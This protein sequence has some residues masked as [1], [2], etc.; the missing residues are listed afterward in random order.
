[1]PTH[2]AIVALRNSLTGSLLLPADAAYETA[3]QPWNLAIEQR[4]DAVAVPADVD[5]LRALLHAARESGARLAVQPSG[6][7]ASGALTGTVLVRMGAFDDLELDLD[8]G[9][10]K[11]GSGVRWGAVVDALE[12]TGWA[13]PA[14]TSPVV[15][16]AGY[17]LGG[18][19]S[20][21]SRTAGLGSDGLRAAWVLRT[22]GTHERV[23]DDIDA[24]LLWALRGAGGV[25]G[26]VTA[27]EI[28][29]VRTP[30]IWGA[31]LTFDVDD[32]PAVLR[33]VRDLAVDAPSSLNLFVNSM[34]MPDAPQLP[35]EIRGRSFVTVQALSTEGPQER[36][37]DAVRR[38][39]EVRR[40]ITGPTSPAA[41]A[42][43]SNE[44][45]DP[46]PGRG[47]SMALSI[48]DDATIDA[49]LEFRELPEQWP[50]MGIDIRMLG[51]ALDAPRRAG[52]ASLESVGWLVHALVPVIPGVPDEPGEASLVAFRELLAPNEAS[53]T[54]PTFL[55]PDQTLERCGSAD[56][57]ARLR[58]LRARF[59][60]EGLLHDGRLPR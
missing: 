23:D 47:A 57:I 17:A 26:I 5:D 10:A 29:L 53:Q 2:S 8:R 49:L 38:A 33:A 27:L 18:G 55:E 45:T 36:Q 1:M 30:E 52:F 34:R 31:N 14:G 41:L 42:A 6:H 43:A 13:A 24:D 20:W 22:D 35:E 44:P 7:G 25:V 59:D 15:S 50:I 11:V 21:F 39:G 54:V 51:G 37:I 58:G 40:D 12:G 32:A 19:H 28:D 46:T 60:P 9:V 48:L 56:G 16:V 4:P 3:R